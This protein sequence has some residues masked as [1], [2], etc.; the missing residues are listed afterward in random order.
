MIKILMADDHAIVRRG[1]RQIL[2]EGA[3]PCQVEEAVNGQ[4]VL[5]KVYDGSFDILVLDISLPDRNGLELVREIKSVKP[6]LPILMLSIHPED[7]YAIRA[8]KAGVSGYLN[9]ESAP[10]QLVQAIQRIVAGGRYIS[11]S[12][13][14]ALA[15][16]VGG[17]TE[18]L[19]HESLSDREFTV[20]LRIGAGKSVS[21]IADELGLSVKTVSTYRARILEKMNMNSNADLIRYVIEHN[22]V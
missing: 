1:L 11:P 22:L 13:A 7:Q 14:E 8:L 18:A 10:E 4:E 12:L 21:E 6:K 3:A 20:L 2:N 15:A 9:K 16:N 19:P 5:S 17:N